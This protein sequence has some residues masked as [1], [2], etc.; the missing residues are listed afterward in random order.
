MGADGDVA[1]PARHR[2]GNG[3]GPQQRAGADDERGTGADERTHGP[4]IETGEGHQAAPVV[5]P[6]RQAGE[7]DHSGPLRKGAGHGGSVDAEPSGEDQQRVE[8]EVDQVEA[9]GDDEWRPRVLMAAPD[10]VSG[11]DQQ[12]RRQAEGADPQVGHG[13]CADAGVGT[14]DPHEERRQHQRQRRQQHPGNHG[15]R[16]CGA[17]GPGRHLRLFA[18]EGGADERCCAVGEE[19]EDEEQ[20]GE[21]RRGDPED[22]QLVGAQP[23]HPSSVDQGDERVGRQRPQSRDRQPSNGPIQ[24]ATLGHGGG[25]LSG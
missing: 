12:D 1:D 13:I 16:D 3:E 7:P 9:G 23:A 20:R 10:A 22:R 18:T 14:H 24:L 6:E 21:D 19:V 11:G 25:V 8:H 5:R 4:P 17:P 15:D 2:R